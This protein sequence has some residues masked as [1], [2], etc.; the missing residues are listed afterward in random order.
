MSG[1]RISYATIVPSLFQP[2]LA[3]GE[4]VAATSIGV[5]LI[6]LVF[7][8]VSQINGCAFCIDKHARDLIKQGDDWQRINSLVGWEETTFYSERE[9]AALAW[10]ES[11][12][13][14]AETHAPDDLF[15]E[16][17]KHFTDVEI[18][19]LTYAITLMNAWN[20]LAIS[21][22]QPVNRAPSVEEA[23][24]ILQK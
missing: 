22:R 14:I 24:R 20:R 12:T 9:R 15:N 23:V 16:L 2:M 4:A 21:F 6:D 3:F 19:E 11:V 13:R 10:A 7:L 8:R 17:K 18:T 5:K 1:L